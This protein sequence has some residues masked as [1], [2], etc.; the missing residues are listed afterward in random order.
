MWAVLYVCVLRT[1]GSKT[2]CVC[3]CVQDD[4]LNAF[5]RTRPTVNEDDLKELQKFTDDFG[6]EG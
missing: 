1:P 6:Q 4:M 2:F 5:R 3:V